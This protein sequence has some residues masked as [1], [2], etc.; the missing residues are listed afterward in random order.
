MQQTDMNV[1]I[2]KFYKV[3]PIFFV[4]FLTLFLNIFSINMLFAVEIDDV[5]QFNVTDIDIQKNQV[6]I[7]LITKDDFKIYQENLSYEYRP[8]MGFPEVVSYSATPKAKFVYDPFMDKEVFVYQHGTN[9][10]LETSSPIAIG[11]KILIKVQGCSGDVCLLPTTLEL[12]IESG[13]R[14]H[15]VSKNTP[16]LYDSQSATTPKINAEIQTSTPSRPIME[17]KSFANTILNLLKTGSLL[18]LP[19]LFV[20]GLLTNLTP[21]VYPMIPITLSVMSQFGKQNKS[22]LKLSLVY[23]FGMVVTYSILGVVAAMTGQV[24]GS[25]LAS[26]LLNGFV[27]LIMVLLG[28]AMLDFFDLSFLQKLSY[29][30]P[31]VESSPFVAVGTMGAVSGLV[32][33]PCTGPILSMI[34]VLIAQTKDPFAGFLYMFCYALGFGAPYVVLGVLSQKLTKL[35]KMNAVTTSI[36]FFFAA[37][38]FGLALYF[39][40]TT[41]NTITF[42]NFLYVRP[43]WFD[44]LVVFALLFLFAAVRKPKYQAFAKYAYFGMVATASIL[45]LWLTLW[46]SNSFVVSRQHLQSM[47]FEDI[48]KTSK[49]AWKTDLQVASVEA[50]NQNK[51]ILVDVWAEWCAACLEM[52]AD[53]WQN[54]RIIDLINEQYIPVKFDY[55]RP[56]NKVSDLL[57]QWGVVGL[58]AILIIEP[59]HLN[60]PLSISQGA[61]STDELL[62]ALSQ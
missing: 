7:S 32:A 41:L 26:P 10:F 9:F 53:T 18:L 61:L 49:I 14:S 16:Q 34:L 42:F 25:Q 3:F 57:N 33:A 56:T 13:A 43:E 1:K 24:F 22:S 28:L 11:D 27:A 15:F 17:D 52:E 55:T 21:C 31:F 23:V 38:M 30:I 4:F 48:L 44:I 35:P 2:D 37:L 51:K 19:L 40:K 46:L 29:K 60:S 20:A 5:I 58:P 50:R 6:S 47:A 39:L 54:S 36:K 45:C 8:N 12:P 59:N 62:K